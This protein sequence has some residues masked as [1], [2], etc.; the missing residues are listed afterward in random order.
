MKW[1]KVN[2]ADKKEYIPSTQAV[3]GGEPLDSWRA[4]NI[5]IGQDAA[6]AAHSRVVF[7]L[8]MNGAAR[9]RFADRISTGSISAGVTQPVPR[10]DDYV[11]VGRGAWRGTP[12][13]QLR[14]DIAALP[15][16]AVVG[17]LVNLPIIGFP[18]SG[19]FGQLICHLTATDMRTNLTAS[20]RETFSTTPIISG[21][22]PGNQNVW[23]LI[24][25]FHRLDSRPT[26][27][28]VN[29]EI[30]ARFSE[31]TNYSIRVEHR[32][33]PRIVSL[34]VSEVPLSHATFHRSGSNSSAHAYFVNGHAPAQHPTQYP[35]TALIDGTTFQEYRYGDNHVINVAENQRKRLGPM[36]MNW[37]NYNETS[38][39]PSGSYEIDTIAPGGSSLR[40][41]LS[42][43]HTTWAP[44]Q[45]G[46]VMPY[47]L[48]H[49]TADD[50]LIMQGKGSVIPCRAQ[51]FGRV[52]T[53]NT[54]GTIK[55][56][57]SQASFYDFFITGTQASNQFFETPTMFLECNTAPDDRSA[58]LQIFF[59]SNRLEVSCI[60]VYACSDHER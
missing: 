29:P 55:F 30:Q 53:S 14:F 26:N 18:Y 50:F 24:D 59:A 4:R 28:W 1:K 15:N 51:I 44:N 57:T 20:W 33:A 37:N 35:Q 38:T 17:P 2:L 31:Q 42:S 19:S 47:Y 32:G 58:I 54:T 11:T 45:P 48:N 8:T 7:E 3:A 16:G 39:P 40:S 5:M 36:I 60:Q 10:Q 22:L 41:I 23:G 43:S 27:F 6:L 49:D 21:A 9:F 52:T 34:C 13:S 25:T 46:W 12:G 56:Q